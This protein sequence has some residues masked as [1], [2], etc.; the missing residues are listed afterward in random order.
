MKASA[1]SF[2]FRF[3]ESSNLA[4]QMAAIPNIV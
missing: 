1:N 4:Y 3:I 2:Q